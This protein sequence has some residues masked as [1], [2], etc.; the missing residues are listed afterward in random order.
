MIQFR[1]LNLMAERFPI[2]TPLD[3]IF[4]RNVMIYFD[5]PTQETLVNKFYGYLKPGGYLF[6]GHSE[7]LQ[8][9]KHP[10]QTVAPTVYYKAP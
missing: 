10:F 4:C 6:I 1:R 5:R 8:W 3:L 7:S 2:T 9:V